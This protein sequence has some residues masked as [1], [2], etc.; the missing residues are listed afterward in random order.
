LAAEQRG[1]LDQMQQLELRQNRLQLDQHA[2][3]APDSHH[4]E[5]LEIQLLQAQTSAQ[6]LSLDL[7]NLE[8]QTPSLEEDRKS[9]QD[10][11]NQQSA[12]LVEFQAR[13][14]ALTALQ[15]KLRTDER[16]VPWL[17]KHGLQ[18]LKPLW[19]RVHVTPGWEQAFEAALRERL[20]ALR[21]ANSTAS[22]PL[23]RMFLWPS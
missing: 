23:H 14:Q 12:K 9:A 20:A 17:A 3:A 18:N 19:N 1:L 15:E 6:Q 21:S 10:N 8:A 13:H 4:V 11:S 5:R 7:Q 22:K 2:L 16:L